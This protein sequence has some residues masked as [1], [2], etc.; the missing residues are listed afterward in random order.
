MNFAE[1]QKAL[2]EQNT[3]AKS[4]SAAQVDA[5]GNTAV[6]NAAAAGANSGA[7]T[8]EEDDGNGNGDLGDGSPMIKSFKLVLEDGTEMEAQDATEMVK[9]LVGEINKVKTDAAA[10]SDELMKSLGSAVELIG[11]LTEG[12][13]AT[14]EDVLALAKRGDELAAT[15]ALMAKSLGVIG[16]QGR[17]KRSVDV[18][19]GARP[20]LN[21]NG[22]AAEVKHTPTE[23]LAKAQ[24]ALTAGTITGTEATKV[25]T[26]LNMGVMPE[27]A[28]LDRIFK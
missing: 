4:L 17:G 2:A 12:L 27:K 1:L 6:A 24:G 26:A 13:K 21:G 3:L 20:D 5:N 25:M 11:T 9:C 14:R 15:N 10:Q 22:G 19:L 28:I 8:E 18:T 16:N 23:I 7:E